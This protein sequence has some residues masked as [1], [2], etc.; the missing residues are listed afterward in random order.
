MTSVPL[1]ELA[2]CDQ[3][4][5]NFLTLMPTVQTHA[6][7][8]FAN[9]P[10]DQREEAIQEAVASACISYRTLVAQGKLHRVRPSALA[11][12]AVKHVRSGRHVGGQQNSN[13]V[14]SELAQK[15][16]G[17][18][19]QSL[20]AP[21]K[22]QQAW[23]ALLTEDRRM[24]PAELAAFRLDFAEWLRGFPRRDRRIITALASG[25]RASAVADQFGLSAGRVSQLR[26]RFEHDWHVFQAE[27]VP[28]AEVG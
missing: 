23:Q 15:K 16:H 7:I 10:A 19:L 26:R 24:W 1:S 9:L 11:D 22:D 6:R 8:Q 27:V 3:W 4:Q 21:Q 12:F 17:L 14:H 18:Q 13:D 2:V 5:A 25:E 20:A 28:M